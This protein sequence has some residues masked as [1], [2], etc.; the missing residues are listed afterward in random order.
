MSRA[1]TVSV[2]LDSPSSKLPPEQPMKFCWQH[3]MAFLA[4]VPNASTL[5]LQNTSKDPQAAWSG[6]LQQQPHFLEP[7]FC[8]SDLSHFVTKYLIIERKWVL[9]WLL[10]PGHAVHHDRDSVAADQEGGLAILSPQSESRKRWMLAP[11]PLSSFYSV[12]RLGS[13]HFSS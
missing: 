8:I 9:F 4:K 12:C 2:S 7:M 1:S 6:S 3:S 5:F 11:S 13:S 10:V